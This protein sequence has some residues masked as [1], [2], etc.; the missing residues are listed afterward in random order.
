MP[1]VAALLKQE[2]T[3]LARKEARGATHVLKKVSA[4]HR[5]AIAALRRQ[6]AQL[7]RRLATLGR[8]LERGAGTAPPAPETPKV[9]FV[10]RGLRSQRARLGLSAAEFGKLVGVS[11]QSVYNWEQGA[12]R[13]RAAQLSAL[14]ALRGI[15]KREAQARLAQVGTQ[16]AGRRRKVRR[17]G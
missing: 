17:R 12:A 5:H 15:G 16:A 3:R 14:V 10:A 1:N 11:A 4:Q 2:I 7:Q 6:I 13:P 8:R 9:R